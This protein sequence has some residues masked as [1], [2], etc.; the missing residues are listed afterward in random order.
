MDGKYVRTSDRKDYAVSPGGRTL[1]DMVKDAG[2]VVYTVG[3]INDIFNGQGV[4]ISVHTKS[5][6]DGID[7]TIQALN[8][9]FEGLI[10]TNLVDFDSLY[11]HRRDGV[12][13]G[14]ALEEFDSRLPEV[15][16]AMKED[17]LIICAD[18]GN[19]PAIRMDHITR[20][21][22]IYGESIQPGV[23]LEP[24]QL[25]RI[26]RRRRRNILRLKQLHRQSF[27]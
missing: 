22:L 10:F 14:T 26:L 23:N 27:V 19:D 15:K 4:S 17:I 18:H 7:K 12:G 8:A 2:K 3:K 20:P 13:Y 16:D 24:V 9:D 1:L 21:A 5:N 11:G 25:L 6:Q